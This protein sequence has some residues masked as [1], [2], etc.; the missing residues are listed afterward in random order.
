MASHPNATNAAMEGRGFYNRNSAMQAAGIASV[1]PHWLAAA[2][3]V[4]IG[5]EPIVIADYGSSQGKN[6]MTPMAVAIET[7]RR[8]VGSERTVEVYHTD[9]PSNDFSTLFEALLTDPASYLSDLDRVYPSAI[10]RSYFDQIIPSERVHLAWNSWTL[11]WMSRSPADAPDHIF[12][13]KSALP[14][15]VNAVRI[16]QADDWQRFLRLRCLELRPGGRMLCVFAGDNEAGQSWRWL[17]GELWNALCDMG[18]A[19]LVSD[20][21]RLRITVPTAPRRLPDIVAPFDQSGRFEDLI[22]EHVEIA[23]APDP[24][25]QPFLETGDREVLAKSHCGMVRG[26]SGP[27]IRQALS[28]ER[29][30]EA[31]VD[32]LF[33]RFA[34]RIAAAP[35]QHVHFVGIVVLAKVDK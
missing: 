3:R 19:G 16:Q 7:L 33:D 22:L 26:F 13:A 18:R 14:A 2:E 23:P 4:T 8:R 28:A 27:T 25:W 21:E 30:R 34:T 15:V 10:G 24:Y 17:T 35:Q 5:D 11:Q 6:S 32:E 29:D 9:L 20:E 31:L 1:M 12:A